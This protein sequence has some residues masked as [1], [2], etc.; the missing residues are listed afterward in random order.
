MTEERSAPPAHAEAVER[1]AV[2]YVRTWTE[3][4][5]FVLGQITGQPFP[6]AHST[7][8]P[9]ECPA[10][11]ETDHR[12]IVASS[13][14]VRGEMSVRIPRRTVIE[15]AQ[16]F[17]GE[18]PDGSAEFK[19][20]H[21]EAFEE[22]L[23]QAAGHVVT[24]VKA[25]WGEAPIQIASAA[26]PPSWSVAATEWLFAQPE[27]PCRLWM[28][29]Q[30]SAALQASLAAAAHA[31]EEAALPAAASGTQLPAASVAAAPAG[32]LDLLMDVELAVTLRFGSRNML[33]SDILELGAGA[34]V[35]LDR[36]VEEPA[37]LLLDGKLI[38]RGEVVV[39]DGNYGLR[40]LDVVLPRI[41]HGL[42]PGSGR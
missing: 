7:G 3:S 4:L 26:T 23:R 39:V 25:A 13:G 15:V 10:A 41:D 18:P 34:V 2:E 21:Q 42:P 5:S 40:V 35:E 37:E 9:P 8:L 27:A 29:C 33:L 11:T 16:V 22:F 6:M 36:R 1:P 31:A 12:L 38:A 20:D 32:N 17:I 28:E 30:I 19:P 14:S 24:S